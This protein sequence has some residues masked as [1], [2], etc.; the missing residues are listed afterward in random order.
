MRHSL[1]CLFVLPVAAAA[2]VGL[3]LTTFRQSYSRASRADWHASGTTYAERLDGSSVLRYGGLGG[4]IDW[5]LAMLS[6]NLDLDLDARALVTGGAQD[7]VWQDTAFVGGRKVVGTALIRP[8]GTCHVYLPGT[9]VFV[10]TGL[11]A[12]V[13][14]GL[15]EKRY[16]ELWDRTQVLQLSLNDAQAGLGYGRMRDAWPL[17]RAVRLVRIL[18][19]EKVLTHQLSDA[20]L[21]D[22]GELVSRS[23]KL[24]YAHERAAKFYYDSLE[25]WLLH[26]GAIREPL[27]A[28]TLFRLDE[29]AVIGS[30]Q[31]RFGMRGF[32]TA[33]VAGFFLSERHDLTD[34]AWTVLDTSI[35]PS[36]RIGW[37]FGGLG[38]LRW[39]YGASAA[40]FLPWPVM[41][42]SGV[43][44]RA[45]LA[46][47][48]AY[49]I[50]DR[51]V[52]G[53]ELDLEPAYRVAVARGAYAR[54]S[55]PAV[56]TA[57]FSYYASERFAVRLGGNYT[58][59]LDLSTDGRHVYPAFRQ[60][61]TAALTMTFGRIPAG[62]G[63]FH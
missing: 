3:D 19:E 27:P 17:Y 34:T 52:A 32:I 24:F 60:R 57:T 35:R 6:D 20:E 12:A 58:A 29:T 25:A 49:D 23:W 46:G 59:Q 9:D 51:L 48:A 28:Y 33:D 47:T 13:D 40:Y 8:T 36:Y 15:A 41:P 38:G 56:Q 53:Y 1:A 21:R 14:A 31:R 11:D 63:V 18:E 55:L 50:T 22:L 10:L 39:S 44:H 26:S 30:D 42:D 45:A 2:S 37:E 7:G 62:W 16:G 61:W 43:R 54:I 4:G 5:R